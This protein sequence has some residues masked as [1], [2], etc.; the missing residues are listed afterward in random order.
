MSDAAKKFLVSWDQ[1]HRDGKA[2]AGL[3][4]NRQEWKGVVAVTRGGLI[5]AGIITRELDIRLVE[6]F[7]V[8]SY[9]D[10]NEQGRADILKDLE[11]L[12]DGAGWIVVDDLVDSGGT[13]KLIRESLS[14]AH[15][16]CIYGKP[17]GLPYTDTHVIQVPQDTWVYF[18]WDME[19]QYV[20]PLS[21]G[22]KYK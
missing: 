9:S 20:E 7:C 5:P 18:P 12:G 13:F 15:F 16:A 4:H 2:L 3:L 21:Q 11:H 14:A 10:D 19:V 17:D 22:P 8:A 6:T 1:I